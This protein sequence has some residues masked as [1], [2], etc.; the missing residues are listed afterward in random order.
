MKV[1]SEQSSLSKPLAQIYLYIKT[2]FYK[3]DIL[4]QTIELWQEGMDG[5][6][7]ISV[8]LYTKKESHMVGNIS[9]LF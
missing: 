2:Y 9:I 6:V 7:D 3:F 4:F 8:K 5:E 1:D